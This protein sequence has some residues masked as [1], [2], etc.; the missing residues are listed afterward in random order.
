M[1]DCGIK[2]YDELPARVGW[3]DVDYLRWRL[4]CCD[5]PS[6][7]HKIPI[8]GWMLTPSSSFKTRQEV[9]DRLEEAKRR[10]NEA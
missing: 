7:I 2:D 5:H 4:A 3:I 8:L 6:F 10:V 9:I 1:A